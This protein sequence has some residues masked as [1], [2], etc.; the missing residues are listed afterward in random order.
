M[1]DSFAHLPATDQHHQIEGFLCPMCKVDFKAPDRLTAHFDAEHSEQDQDLLQSFRGILL[2][3][4]KRIRNEFGSTAAAAS[5]DSYAASARSSSRDQSQQQQ[6]RNTSAYPPIFR[7]D[8]ADAQ[9]IGTDVEHTAYFVAIRAVRLERFATET[10]KLIIRLHKL[11]TDRPSDAVQRKHHE[12]S[13]KYTKILRVF[14]I[15]Y[16]INTIWF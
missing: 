4:K 14:S 3:A 1:S 15:N 13:V 16:G 6:P 5:D 9:P 10:N 12:Q 11:L 7:D 2:G 8:A